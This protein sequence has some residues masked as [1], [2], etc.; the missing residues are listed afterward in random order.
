MGRIAVRW[1]RD[2]TLAAP[3]PNLGLP[4]LRLGPLRRVVA[5]GHAHEGQVLQRGRE[6]P[7]GRARPCQRDGHPEQGL[8]A[9]PGGGSPHRPHRVAIR[10]A[11]ADLDARHRRARR[12]FQPHHLLVRLHVPRDAAAQYCTGRGDY[13]RHG[14]V[15]C[16]VYVD[17]PD[18]LGYARE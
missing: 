2:T 15:G 11:P 9:L 8:Q 17:R 6:A 13:H 7:H 4:H 3:L 1:P 14:R 10:H 12:L 16:V 5:P 18:R